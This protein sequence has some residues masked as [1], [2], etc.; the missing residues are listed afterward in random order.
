[1]HAITGLF[2]VFSSA[3]GHLSAVA[4]WR[5]QEALTITQPLF[6]RERN[7]DSSLEMDFVG[8]SEV[9]GFSAG[10]PRGFGPRC[11]LLA[12]AVHEADFSV[13]CRNVVEAMLNIQHSQDLVVRIEAQHE[14]QRHRHAAQAGNKHALPP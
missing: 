14:K 3:S 6:V 10:R 9:V 5:L 2:A 1:M 13:L 11:C 12:F 4:A 8:T 7:D